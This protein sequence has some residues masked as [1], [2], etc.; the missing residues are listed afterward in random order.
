M[1]VG[2]GRVEG[3][4][5]LLAGE[6]VETALVPLVTYPL[7]NKHISSMSLCRKDTSRTHPAANSNTPRP[8]SNPLLKNSFNFEFVLHSLLHRFTF[9]WRHLFNSKSADS[10]DEMSGTTS[11]LSSLAQSVKINQC[12]ESFC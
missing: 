9:G 1:D 10:S 2:E 11:S 6:V 12:I 7:S 8:Q 5:M 3:R 4:T